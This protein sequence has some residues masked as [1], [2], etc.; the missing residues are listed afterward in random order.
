H[1]L[2]GATPMLALPTDHPRPAVQM[3]RGSSIRF[4]VDRA[5]RDALHQLGRAHNTTLFM[6]LFAAFVVLLYRYSGQTD[7]V[8]GSPI[9]N[10]RRS[11][12]EGLLG[13]FVN[14]LALRVDLT[15]APPF[16]TLLE[17]VRRTTL[18]AYSHQDLPFERRVDALQPQ[19]DFSR[20]PLFQVIFT[21][22]N[23]PAVA[24]EVEGLRLSPMHVGRNATLCDLVLDFW[25]ASNGLHGVLEFDI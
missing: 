22:Q 13:F 8:V 11:E 16:S 23:P 19:R 2:S 7:I 5:T 21:L 25:D 10:R 1:Q 6:T 4:T 17:R 15:G 3:F 24:A 14:T 20:N 18:D 12:L 9:A